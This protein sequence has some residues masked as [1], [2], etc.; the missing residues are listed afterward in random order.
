[1]KSSKVKQILNVTQQTLSNYVAKGI[2]HPVKLSKTHYEYDENEVYALLG[3]NKNNDRISVTYARVS[4]PKQ[5]D[6]LERQIERLY[7]YAISNGYNISE[8][9]SDIKSGMEFEKRK[10]FMKLLNMVCENRVKTV[11]VENK[12]RLVRFGFNLL[13]EVFKLHGTEILV[14]S[15]IPNK[16]YEQEL[17]DDLISII[18][19]YS[20][21]S[22]SNRRKLNN[23]E[24]IL[25]GE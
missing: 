23:A 10:N 14:M 5:K 13:K 22:Y 8:Q 11:I 17:T 2:L 18:H 3:K 15:D 16:S 19:Y 21:K 6:D 1:M 12:D 20:M 7:S 24:K 9:L 25:K 4:L